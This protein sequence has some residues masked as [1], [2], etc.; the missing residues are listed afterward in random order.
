MRLEA[1]HKQTSPVIDY[2]RSRGVLRDINA[3]APFQ[4]VSQQIN[5]ALRGAPSAPSR[6]P[7]QPQ[8]ESQPQPG[9][10]TGRL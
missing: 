4:Q 1:F 6:L 8:Q 9:K 7:L 2:Y 3:D 10:M 5:Q